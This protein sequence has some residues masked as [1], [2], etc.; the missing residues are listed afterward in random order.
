MKQFA[1]LN[2]KTK[3]ALFLGRRLLMEDILNQKITV[4]AYKIEASKF[5]ERGNGNRLCI[6]FEMADNPNKRLI[7]FTGSGSLMDIMNNTTEY[8]FPFQ[9]T[10]VKV[11]MGSKFTYKFT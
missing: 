3:P 5:K 9:G 1:E 4:H 2:I 11:G 10:I 8:D 7:V 6:D